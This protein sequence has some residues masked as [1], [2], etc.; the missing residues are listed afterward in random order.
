MARLALGIVNA[1][2]SAYGRSGPR[3][4]PMQILDYGAVFLLAFGIEAALL[5]QDCW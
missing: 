5:R 2:L 4:L 1:S 3:A